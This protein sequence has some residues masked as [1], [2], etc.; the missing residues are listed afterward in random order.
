M[1]E[2]KVSLFRPKDSDVFYM[3][4]REPV[5]GRKIRRTTG[6]RSRRD[7]M[8]VAATWESEIAAGRGERPGKL[9]WEQFRINSKTSHSTAWPT[10]RSPRPSVF[11]MCSNEP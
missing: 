4:Y 10:R 6:K 11:S 1:N 8:R 9:S 7:A 2:I 5:S 3:Q